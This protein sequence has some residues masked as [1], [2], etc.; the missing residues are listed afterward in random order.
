MK[1]I[2]TLLAFIVIAIYSFAYD[3]KIGGIYY[4][5]DKDRKTAEV[6]HNEVEDSYGS[7][8]G[9][10]YSGSVIIPSYIS[11]GGIN[12]SVSRIGQLAFYNCNSL[13]SVIIP[14]SV[15]II[16]ED[17][18]FGCTSLTSVIIPNSVTS[19]GQSAFEKSGLTSIQVPNSVTKIELYTF[20]DCSNLKSVTIPSSVTEIGAYAFLRCSNLYTVTIPNS[21]TRIGE[22][23]FGTCSILNTVTLGTSVTNIHTEAFANCVNLEK[24]YC[25]AQRVPSTS[26]S[27]FK[28][29]GVNY[30]TLY[31]PN[32]LIKGYK[33]T[34]PWSEFGN[35][36]PIEDVLDG[37]SS[38]TTSG[39]VADDENIYNLNGIKV[40]DKIPFGIYVKNGKKILAK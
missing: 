6:T 33:S 35:I 14:N 18:F 29:S 37:I 1:R 10:S 20:Y 8:V 39:V 28:K 13:I 31:V 27:A 16:G 11:Y 36:L 25:L 32:T 21:V 4:N 34:S 23:A 3:V 38:A 5:L 17:A 24:V 19:I 22:K 30:A 7:L 12:F 9:N 15:T 26:S 40:N 2:L